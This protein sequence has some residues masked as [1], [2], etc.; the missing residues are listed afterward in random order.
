LKTAEKPSNIA[1]QILYIKKHSVD[2]CFRDNCFRQ[3]SLENY[4]SP[5]CNYSTGCKKA[6]ADL[7]DRSRNLA[8]GCEKYLI[9]L[10][11]QVVQRK[12]Y[13]VVL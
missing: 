3:L 6:L 2:N 5:L 7:S 11:V 8:E 13:I 10:Y 12:E 9:I 1:R 4:K